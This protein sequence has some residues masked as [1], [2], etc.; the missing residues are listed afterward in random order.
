MSTDTK[1][2]LESLAQTEGLDEETKAAILKV[3]E[4]EALSKAL[5]EDIMRQA[6]FSRKHDAL[7]KDR[8]ALDAEKQKYSDWYAK[9]SPEYEAALKE[10]DALLEKYGPLDVNDPNPNPDP[11]NIDLS[12]YMTKEEVEKARGQDAAA[13]VKL[14]KDVA[15]ITADYTQRFGETL[16]V[17]DIEAFAVKEGL[18][19]RAAYD[20]FIA[21]KTAEAEKAAWEAKVAEARKEEREAVMSEHNFPK[22][23]KPSEPGPLFKD[24][25]KEGE[26][27]TKNQLRDRFRQSWET[28]QNAP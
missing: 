17:D 25:P 4:N 13:T 28:V 15:I 1:K 21:P 10:R 19:L 23:A 9:A 22:D 14:L 18:P 2:Y 3:G 11:S 27:V 5:G 8:E 7:S 16:P 20:K 12:K 26:E 6:D 24:P